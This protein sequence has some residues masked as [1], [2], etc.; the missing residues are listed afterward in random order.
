MGRVCAWLVLTFAV[1]GCA[2]LESLR[3][4]PRPVPEVAVSTRLAQAISRRTSLPGALP[5]TAGA[6]EI[7]ETV[8][9]PIVLNPDT[10]VHMVHQMSPSVMASREEKEAAGHQ[11]VEFKANLSRL[12]PFLEANADVSDFP[13]RREAERTTGELVAGIEKEMFDG[14]QFRV[15]GGASASHVEFGEVSE[16]QDEVE[17]GSGVLVRARIE[18]PFVGSRIRQNRIISQAF[19]ESTARRAELDYLTAYR[20]WVLYALIYYW[21]AILWGDYVRAAEEQIAAIETLGANER[22]D[23]ADRARCESTATAVRVLR[24]RYTA[25]RR[26]EVAAMLAVLG[27][28]QDAPIT[29]GASDYEASVYAERARTPE[30]RQNL[31][32]D[33]RRNNPKFHVLR[34]AIR[35]ARLQRE[36]AIAGK[37]DITFFLQGSQF[38]LGS[39][40]FDDRVDGWL[41]EGGLRMRLNDQRVLRASRLKAEAETRQF[42]AQIEEEQRRIEQQ[43]IGEADRLRL[44]NELLPKILE[45][46]ET[47]RS[48][49]KDR[50]EAFL[51]ENQPALT[52]DDVLLPLEELRDAATGLADNVWRSRRADIRLMGA[53]GDVYR[54]VGM[55]IPNGIEQKLEISHATPDKE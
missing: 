22:L 18:I 24:D 51:G 11:L 25:S 2:V 52:I 9:P 38:P 31:L 30:G 49:F 27:M 32:E 36:Q 53:T 54:M 33:A 14:A 50:S 47:K 48:E 44:N 10:I 5:S 12:E 19:Q 42:E 1:T 20:T 3:L 39:E 23:D 6:A 28:D 15:E 29:L 34:D 43:I 17:S 21:D 8:R 40:T 45:E 13:A 41:I 4:S 55:D 16:G 7:D 46:V 26:A 37:L 35:N